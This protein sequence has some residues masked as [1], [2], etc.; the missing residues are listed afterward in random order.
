MKIYIII[1]VSILL[2]GCT[3]IY[4][5]EQKRRGP[6]IIPQEEPEEKKNA[7]ID[8]EAIFNIGPVEIF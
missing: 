4:K 2:S 6:Q 3:I 7:S 5:C 1:I 8:R